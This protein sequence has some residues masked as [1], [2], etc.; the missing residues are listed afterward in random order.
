MATL[1]VTNEGLKLVCISG[2]FDNG[3][4]IWKQAGVVIVN[5]SGKVNIII[6]KTFNP[7]G[8]VGDNNKTGVI[9]SVVPYSVEELKTKVIRKREAFVPTLT[10]KPEIKP[11]T[12]SR[13]P[14]SFA[15]TLDDMNDDIP[16]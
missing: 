5:K 4:P 6:D 16:F 9:L 15:G 13:Y 7:A 14:S 3:D 8:V 1:E 10:P 12:E 2:Y 11:F